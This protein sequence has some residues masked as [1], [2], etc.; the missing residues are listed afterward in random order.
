MDYKYSFV[1]DGITHEYVG[2]RPTNGNAAIICVAQIE[3]SHELWELDPINPRTGLYNLKQF[4]Y[5]RDGSSWPHQ[6]F[7]ISFEF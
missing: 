4:W 3:D 6:I 1:K 2:F 7:R 5:V